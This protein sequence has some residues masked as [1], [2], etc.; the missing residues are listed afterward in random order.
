MKRL[1]VAAVAAFACTALTLTACGQGTVPSSGLEDCLTDPAG[2]NSGERIEGGE[3][4]WALD[5]SW[6]AWNQNTAEGNNAYVATALVGMWP[7]PGQFDPDGTFIVN[8]GLFAADPALVSENPV[9][10]EYTLKPGANW[11]DGTNLSVDDFIYN[12]YARSG[13]ED[14]CKGCTPATTTYGSQVASITGEGSKVTVVY[15]DG[16]SSAEWMYADVLSQPAHVAEAEGFDWKNDPEQMK[17]A[18]DFFSETVPTWSTGPFKIS[19]AVAGDYVQYVR[20]DAWA[21]DTKVTLDKLTFR[22]FDGLD[23]IVTALRNGEID[24]AA[25]AAVTSEAISQLEGT[26]GVS[27]AVAGGPNWEHVDVNTRHEFL[28][29]VVLRQAVLTAIDVENIIARTYAFVQSDVQ[30]K[31]NHLFRTGSEYYVDHLSATGQGSGDIEMA[32]GILERAGYEWDETDQLHTPDGEKVEFDFRY[33]QSKESR[34]VTAELAQANLAGL[35]IDVEIRAIPDADLGKVLSEGDFD[36]IA[37]GWSTDPQFVSAASQYWDSESQSNFGGLDDPELDDLIAAISGTLDYDEAAERAN[38]AVKQVIGDAYVLPIV[39]TPVA[40]MVS[41][42]L[43][44]VRDNWASQQRAT[45]NLAEWGV[46][47]S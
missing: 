39:D 14:L 26:E 30:R 15:K 23:N 47:E 22:V 28:D 41:D 5:G 20:N 42:R 18:E 45:Y 43:V 24:G 13:D 40:V 27:Y 32:R 2:C 33:S 3:I 10:V 17:A 25:P 31:N 29:D 9:T 21:G 38:A 12:W 19:Q 46:S 44:N 34:Q 16:Y 1:H 11:G 37:Y 8:E 7:Y 4:T 6:A 36:L 35:G